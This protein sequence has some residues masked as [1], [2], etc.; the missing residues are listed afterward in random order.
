MSANNAFMELHEEWE[1][2]TSWPTAE[3]ENQSE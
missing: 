2:L 3:I 1:E